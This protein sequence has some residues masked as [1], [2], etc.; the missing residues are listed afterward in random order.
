MKKLLM[1]GVV[2]GV[3]AAL[4]LSSRVVVNETQLPASKNSD[5]CVSHTVSILEGQFSPREVNAT[6]CDKLIFV[7]GDSRDYLLAF[8]EHDEHTPYGD[9]AER[10]LKS[11]ESFQIEL[12]YRGAYRFHDHNN[13][14]MNGILRVE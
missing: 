13:D 12:V 3:V 6:Y 11:G 4:L 7:N 2:L 10:V 5:E 9:F 8:G 1:S 14:E